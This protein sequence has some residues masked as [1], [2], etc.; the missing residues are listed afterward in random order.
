[1]IDERHIAIL[2]AVA[3]FFVLNRAQVQRLC[4]PTD[5]GGR[6]TRRHLA[7]LIQQGL[8]GRL[9]VEVVVPGSG[10]TAPVYHPTRKGL[11]F[12]VEFTEDPRWLDVSTRRPNPHH[13]FHWL[14]ISETHLVLDAAL[15]AQREV[16]CVDWL[17]EWDV[18][19]A[20][21][22]EPE[23]KFRLYTLIQPKPRL[24]CAPDAA[25]LLA[26]D[27]ET[28]VFYLEQD[29]NTSGVYQIACSKS[30]GYAALA[31][32]GLHRRHFPTATLDRFAVL[33][34]SPTARRR[35]ALRRALADRDG[36]ALWR[37]A[38][39]DELTPDALLFEPVWHRCD[40]PAG[41]LVQPAV[42]VA[43]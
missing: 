43:S 40:G 13:L 27:G 39:M 3:R 5:G 12:L 9:Q 8:L 31:A 26:V 30:P 18:A 2:R 33:S 36:A 23:R 25:F 17:N 6:V 7:A 1:M 14:A 38:A 42:E 24:V 35:D 15:A 10:S 32:R 11:E 21:A 29:R 19:H 16:C 4:F 28:K 41:P 22:A 34:V 37:F 20:E